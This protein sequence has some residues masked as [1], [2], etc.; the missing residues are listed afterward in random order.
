MR[1][2]DRSVPRVLLLLPT[3]TYRAPDFV[4][5]AARLGVEVVVGSEEAPGAGSRRWA[6]GRW[7]CRSTTPRPAADA[8][9]ALDDRAAVDAVV[10]VDDR[11]VLVAAAAAERLGFP[12]NPPDAVA[13][14]RDKAAMRRALARGGGAAAARSSSTIRHCP[15]SRYP[16]G[17]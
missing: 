12:H 8:I 4:R 6:T 13:A 10:A 9:V 15:T 7:W 17:A 11:G 14:T 5:A 1:R 16:L 2:H 3:S